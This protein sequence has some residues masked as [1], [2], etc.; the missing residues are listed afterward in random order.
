MRLLIEIQGIT[1]LLLNR[2]TDKAALAATSGSRGSSSGAD[3]GTEH[4]IAESKLYCDETGLPCVPVQNLM[5]C[6]VDGGKFH[7]I[8]KKQVTTKEESM[9]FSCVDVRGVMLPI[10]HNAPWQVD[11]RPVVIPATKGRILT[12]RPRFDDWRLTFEVDLD[13]NIVNAKLFR[14]IVDDAGSRIGLGDFRPARKGP[15]GRFS[16]VRWQ[17]IDVVVP[18]VSEAAE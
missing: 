8:G 7:K 17:E 3:R 10:E 12:Y 5:R 2:F 1:G 15:Y 6:L 18:L 13:V 9:L 4:E 11:I 14:C 16:V